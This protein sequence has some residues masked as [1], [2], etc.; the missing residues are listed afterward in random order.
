MKATLTELL[1]KVFLELWYEASSSRDM[2]NCV[3]PA[4]LIVVTLDDFNE[5]TDDFI[6][7][8]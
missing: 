6:N 2:Y 3:G 5:C 4:A 7:D 1:D 8:L